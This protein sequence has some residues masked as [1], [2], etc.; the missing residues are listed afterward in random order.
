[1]LSITKKSKELFLKRTRDI[2]DLS[3]RLDWRA[4]EALS[5][6][7]FESFG[8]T[9]VRNYRLK[10][11]AAEIDILAIKDG[12][13]FAIDCKHWKRT[14]GTATMQKIS[15]RQIK[16]AQRVVQLENIQNVTPVILTLHD[17]SLHI[18]ENGTPIVPIQ[19]ISDFVLNWESDR[20]IKVIFKR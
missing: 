9:T 13:G 7:I 15:E 18:L 19:K 11:P 10:R 12:L 2:E 16:R 5:E 4:F 20:R 17:E 6:S 8:F 3:A 14:V 1:M